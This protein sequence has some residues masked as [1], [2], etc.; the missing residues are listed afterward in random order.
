M[1][2][3]LKSSQEPLMRAPFRISEVASYNGVS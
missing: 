1:D 2:T 3:A